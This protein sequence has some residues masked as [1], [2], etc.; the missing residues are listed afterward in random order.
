MS[1]QSSPDIKEPSVL[2]ISE[3]IADK[4]KA[5]INEHCQ[6]ESYQYAAFSFVVDAI[7]PLAYLEMHWKK[8]SY[9]YYWEKPSDEFAIAAGDELLDISTSGTNRFA[10]AQTK[11]SALKKTTIEF[12][13]VSHPYSG[14]TFLGGFSFFD[15][16]A[17]GFWS[18]FSPASLSVP[19]WLIIKDSKFNLATITVNLHSFETPDLLYH[20]I[21]KQLIKLSDTIHSDVQPGS[22]IH[23]NSKINA[24]LPD[25][26]N[27]GYDH[28]ISSVEQAKKQIIQNTFDKIVLARHISIPYNSAI[29]P[30]QIIN[31]LRQQYS[32]CYNFLVHHPNENTFLG[33]TPERLGSFR[34]R[35]FLTEALAGSMK[36]GRTATE[37]SMLEKNL[38]SSRK[39]RNEHNFVI[40]AIEERIAPYAESINRSHQPEIKKLSN[41]QHLYTP[42]RIR[43]KPDTDILEV[44]EQ[45]HPTPAVGGYPWQKA[46]PFI[47]ELEDFDRGWYAGP[48]GWLNSKGTG[49]FAVAI[50]S[51]LLNENEAHFFAGCGIVAD[52]DPAAEWEETN[53]KLKPMLSALQYD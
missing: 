44:I 12:S 32:N 36:R 38:S 16:P 21:I 3:Q 26:S 39:N 48:V 25:I 18:S 20:Y 13:A 10:D 41:V 1:D 34:N 27:T 5:F 28:W 23:N 51:G 14:M 7:D 35:L 17:N 11:V 50:R 43:L 9:Q 53:L 15:K 8:D 6:S 33:S 45:L 49:E 2:P 30:T 4:L 52:S 31:T 24:S 19:K 46:K 37:D 40:K 47:T 22:G 29:A 42:I